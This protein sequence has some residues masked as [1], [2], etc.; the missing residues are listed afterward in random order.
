MHTTREQF[1]TI[2]SH[3]TAFVKLLAFVLKGWAALNDEPMTCQAV[4][5][6]LDQILSEPFPNLF[7]DLTDAQNNAV[8]M[9]MMKK[10]GFDEKKYHQP[11]VLEACD[12]PWNDLSDRLLGR[13]ADWNPGNTKRATL[14]LA[15]HL[16]VKH[17]HVKNIKKP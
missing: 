11:E 7:E 8:T 13:K 6:R 10:H 9:S 16:L 15:Y 5:R 2:I 4:E 3:H 17:N 14:D 1:E 12:D